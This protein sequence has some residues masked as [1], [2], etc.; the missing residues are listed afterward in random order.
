MG[1]SDLGRRLEYMGSS[2]HG[3]ELKDLNLGRAAEKLSVPTAELAGGGFGHFQVSG[4]DR[5]A[6]TLLGH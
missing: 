5:Q 4:D 2:P 6:V 1:M 3:L